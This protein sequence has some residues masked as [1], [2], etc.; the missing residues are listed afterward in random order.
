MAQI[1]TVSWTNPASAVAKNFNPGF[2]V[3]KVE[4]LDLTTPGVFTW[5]DQMDDASFFTAS[6]PAYTSSN[7]VTPLTQDTAVG[8]TISGFTNAS[9]GVLTVNDTDTFGFA[10]GDTI[11][12]GRLA[13]D[14]TG[15]ASLNND[16]TIA[17]VTATT[18]T[19]TTDTSTTGY[20]VYGSGGVVV[21]VSDIAG[22]PI[23][24]KNHA[25]QGVT[26][27]TG[28]VGDNDAVMTATFYGKES[29]T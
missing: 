25:I 14:D 17:S 29:V 1:K 18:I 7:G 16:F 20:S 28:C 4:V 10:I 23:P 13:D 27:G 8:A 15:T 19:T 3:A 12:V 9:P 11:R 2:E 24:L 22:T 21:R 26:L 6:T 5:N